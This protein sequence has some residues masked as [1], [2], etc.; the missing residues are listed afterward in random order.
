MKMKRIL[1]LV[2]IT[3]ITLLYGCNDN[4]VKEITNP[5]F[6]TG[7]LKGWE[8]KGEAFSNSGVIFDDKDSLGN[9]YNQEG[10]FFFYGGNAKRFS[11]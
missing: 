6:E 1:S 2:M 5:S 4:Q 7:T 3:T 11:W 9:Y 10:D 8:I